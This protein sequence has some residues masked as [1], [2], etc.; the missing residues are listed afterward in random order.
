MI[1]AGR[2]VR[3]G[4]DPRCWRSRSRR[5]A[6][7]ASR[8]GRLPAATPFPPRFARAQ[9]TWGSNSPARSSCRGPDPTPTCS[10]SRPRS[11]STRRSAAEATRS[12]VS[13]RGSVEPA[14]ARTTTNFERFQT[15]ALKAALGWDVGKSRG[16]LNG[17]TPT[18]ANISD[19]SRQRGDVY[20][21]GKTEEH[22]PGGVSLGLMAT[23]SD[24]T[25]VI[26]GPA[27]Q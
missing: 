25:F 10:T 7:A 21:A 20:I 22:E 12:C 5:G 19:A 14:N 16:V 11:T 2:S 27:A 8:L 9:A 4:W 17:M 1:G 3:C 15:A 13:R 23:D 6:R 18:R 26:V 24:R